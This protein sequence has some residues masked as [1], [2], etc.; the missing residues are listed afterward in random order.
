MSD[1]I[2]SVV[3]WA[4]TAA[5]LALFWVAYR[6]GTG[7]WS[8]WRM[9]V[10]RDGRYSTSLFQ[11]LAWTVVVI[12]TYLAMWFAR[13]H[14]GSLDAIGPVPRNVLVAMGLSLG[15][16]ASAAAITG[17]RVG[18][19]RERRDPGDEAELA[20]RQLICDDHGRPNLAKAQLMAWTAVALAIY[21]AAAVAAV[22]K[23]AAATGTDGLPTLPDI[24]PTLLLLMGIGQGAYLA[25]KA[26]T[27]PEVPGDVAARAGAPQ[28]AGPSDARPAGGQASP[29][30]RPAPAAPV[31]VASGPVGLPSPLAA[32]IAAL[33]PLADSVAGR[34]IPV[35]SIPVPAA[36]LAKTALTALEKVDDPAS[37]AALAAAVKPGAASVPGFAPSV[38][39]L[40]FANSWPH[41]PAIELDL[42]GLGT[43]RA[44][45]AANGLCGGMVYTVRDVFQTP[46]L[47]PVATTVNPALG[48]PLYTY[49]ADRL[50]E[51]FDI[52]H[53]GFARYYEAMLTPDGD[54]MVGPML[55]RRG[56]AWR[57]V[58]EEWGGRIRPELDAGR[59]VCLGV[60]TVAGF[61]PK[62]LGENHQVMA[63]GY[64]LTG[65][66]T[67]TLY[68]YDPN[69]GPDQ[70]D[71]VR[72]SL[73]V[74]NPERPTP[75]AH[76]VA[77]ALPIRGFFATAYTYQDPT[78]RLG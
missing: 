52:G 29:T 77:I 11:G 33:E 36:S 55:V 20:L 25:V 15:T 56:L 21:L 61:D 40:H 34:A 12:A 78:G 23:T 13:V 22:A 27:A 16:T 73:S 44:G 64:D 26:S 62:L 17:R 38:N 46:G 8:L 71:A 39:G 49:I 2:G 67:L 14:L 50:I 70:A 59:L 7:S 31:P 4:A 63:Y 57:T 53:L 5:V 9:A 19:R 58:V 65:D 3:A 30:A 72:L 69:T 18:S 6:L 10:G 75:I 45:D 32:V 54:A 37:A 76:N 41:E 66:G 1:V 51:S 43:L 60:V 47:A 74:L 35:P 68:V 24:E 48:T 28:P 42:P